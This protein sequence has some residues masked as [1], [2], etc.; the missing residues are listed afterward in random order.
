MK[1]LIILIGVLVLCFAACSPENPAGPRNETPDIAI[2]GTWLTWNVGVPYVMTINNTGINYTNSGVD[3]TI[4]KYDNVNRY[5]IVYWNQHPAYALKYE[6]LGWT[7]LSPTNFTIILYPAT[8]N[9]ALAE[10]QTAVWAVMGCTNW[11]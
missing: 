9:A 5:C 7:N 4:T 1:R 8:N 2:E 11:P 6:K 3:A 10:S